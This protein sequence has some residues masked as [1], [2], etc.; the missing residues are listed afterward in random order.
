[1]SSTPKRKKAKTTINHYRRGRELEYKV[2]RELEKDGY[3]AQ[4]SAGS[5]KIDV[6]AFL[7]KD[8]DSE[9]D[10]VKAIMV[11]R[12]TSPAKRKAD[13]DKLLSYN[14]PTIVQKELWVYCPKKRNNHWVIEFITE[15]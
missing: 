2:I 10:V 11:T 12:D 1:M 6:L 9:Q 4:R 5:H 15:D 8:Q 7:K 13:I 3:H 14:L